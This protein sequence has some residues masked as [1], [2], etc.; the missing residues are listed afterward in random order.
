MM[1][2]SHHVNIFDSGADRAAAY[3]VMQTH[4]ALEVGHSRWISWVWLAVAAAAAFFGPDSHIGWALLIV[5][6]GLGIHYQNV[7]A[8]TNARNLAMHII[9]WIE[10]TTPS[11][12]DR[13]EH[14]T[15]HELTS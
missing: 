6:L 8:E 13:T 5:T 11:V 3:A 1:H 12:S 14:K 10:S 9:D 7:R 15:G 2:K 4:L